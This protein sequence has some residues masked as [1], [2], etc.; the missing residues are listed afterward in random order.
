ME[1]SFLVENGIIAALPATSSSLDIQLNWFIHHIRSM[2]SNKKACVKK[3]L[4]KSL[5]FVGEIGG[6]DYNYVFLTGKSIKEVET[7]IPPVVD[8]IINVT[9]VRRRKKSITSAHDEYVVLL[10]YI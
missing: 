9:K 8:K 1:K 10:L 7:Y 4:E 2:C 6:N 3:R 5:F